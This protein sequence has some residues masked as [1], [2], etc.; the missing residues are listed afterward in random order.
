MN[1]DTS[2]ILGLVRWSHLDA[3][4]PPRRVVSEIRRMT[5]KPLSKYGLAL[6]NTLEDCQVNRVNL[7]T[8]QLA[9]EKKIYRPSKL[10]FR[11]Q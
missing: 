10:K 8:F 7:K 9:S 4:N 11:N 6:L 5:A 1:N 3:G 2:S